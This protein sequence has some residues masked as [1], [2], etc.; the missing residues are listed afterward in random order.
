MT[1]LCLI[2]KS[3]I[4]F[5]LRICLGFLRHAEKGDLKQILSQYF[6]A[7]NISFFDKHTCLYLNVGTE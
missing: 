2:N 5:E 4:S 6:T 3:P 7:Q 1:Y